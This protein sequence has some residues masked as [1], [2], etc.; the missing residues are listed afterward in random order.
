[1][2]PPQLRSRYL[3]YL[4][5]KIIHIMCRRNILSRAQM[6][7]RIYIRHW[8]L[9]RFGAFTQSNLLSLPVNND[10]REQYVL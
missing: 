5:I 2:A 6:L 10:F 1:M 8:S 3:V 4:H 7:L 9:F